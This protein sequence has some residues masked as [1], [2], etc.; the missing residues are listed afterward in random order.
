MIRIIIA[1]DHPIIRQGLKQILAA[2]SDMVL[3]GEAGNAREVFELTRKQHYDIIVL[4]ITLPGRSGIEVLKDLKSERPK[5]P[6]L[7]LSMHPEDQYAVRVLKAGAAGYMTKETAPEELAK[8]IRK[9]IRGGKYVSESLAEKL[10]FDLETDTARPPHETLSD[11][12]YEVMRMIAS[13]KTVKQVAEELCLSV[14]TI[15]TYRT[16]ILE[17]MRMKSNAEL[18][19]YAVQNRLVD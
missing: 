19:R 13:G 5:T 15:S 14:K 9:I 4:D 3:V 12:E 17:K 10:A 16:R 18:V 8:A 2:E 6:V 7:V 11:R 1:D